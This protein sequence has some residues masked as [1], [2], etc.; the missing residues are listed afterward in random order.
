MICGVTIHTMFL[1]LSS[2]VKLCR[3]VLLRL[4]TPV[5]PISVGVVVPPYVVSEPSILQA[6][7]A[8]LGLTLAT[9]H[10]RVTSVFSGMED[11]TCTVGVLG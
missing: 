2:L 9:S 10:V 11:G 1:L 7:L 3:K 8:L 4:Y 6:T 5:L